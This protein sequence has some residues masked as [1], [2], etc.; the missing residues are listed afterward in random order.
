[1]K[2]TILIILTIPIFIQNSCK[3]FPVVVSVNHSSYPVLV[4]RIYKIK[5]K[6]YDYPQ[7]L[8]DF[9]KLKIK[10]NSTYLRSSKDNPGGNTK[11]ITETTRTDTIFKFN[12]EMNKIVKPVHGKNKNR[13][14]LMERFIFRVM[15][16][17]DQAYSQIETI[18]RVYINAN[19]K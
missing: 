11:T 16:T 1:M 10:M 4:G 17:F 8:Y 18:G 14:V 19:E 3:L 7:N 15:N 9:K 13:V 5:G 6:K 2:L 12:G